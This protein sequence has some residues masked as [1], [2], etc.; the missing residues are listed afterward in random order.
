MWSSRHKDIT[1]L[2]R[3]NRAPELCP[4]DYR[5]LPLIPLHFA[6]MCPSMVR[7]ELSRENSHVIWLIVAW[8]FIMFKVN[9]AGSTSVRLLILENGFFTPN[10]MIESL[11]LSEIMNGSIC[12][13]GFM[14]ICIHNYRYT[15]WCLEISPLSLSPN[16]FASKA[17]I[18]AS[19]Y[20]VWSINKWQKW[21]IHSIHLCEMAKSPSHARTHWKW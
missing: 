19:I 18:F 8:P 13:M 1:H 3:C 4:A 11:S 17:H 10:W 9:A 14:P 6:Q 12:V 21:M 2:I 15:I 16:V 5:T 20:K 7:A